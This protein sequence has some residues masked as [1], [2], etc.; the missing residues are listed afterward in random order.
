LDL[1]YLRNRPMNMK[2]E[3]GLKRNWQWIEC[4]RTRGTPSY[5]I[6]PTFEEGV[7]CLMAH[8]SYLEKRRVEWDPNNKKIV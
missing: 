5:N 4:I 8:K 1:S 2:R 3:T 7:T 6:E